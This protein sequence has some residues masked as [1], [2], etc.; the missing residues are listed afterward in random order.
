ML[1]YPRDHRNHEL[2]ATSSKK[3]FAAEVITLII[4]QM[5]FYGIN[6]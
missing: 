6:W 2:Q 4:K 5:I 3:Y 1:Y